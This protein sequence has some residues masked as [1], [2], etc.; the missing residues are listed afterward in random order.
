[1][2]DATGEPRIERLS[3]GIPGLDKILS[4]GFI[5][6]GI[7]IVQGNPGAGK[8]ILGNQIC[9]NHIGG[10]GKAAFITLLAESHA[11]MMLNLSELSFFNP[12]VIPKSLYYMSAYSALETEGLKG[13]LELVR[14]E[15]RGHHAS[16][17]VID[18]LVAAE[19]FAETD[20]DLKKFIHELQ[21]Q[22]GLYNCTTLLLTS[23]FGPRSMRPERTMVDGIIELSD[24][25]FSSRRERRLEVTKFRGSAHLRGQHQFEI[26]SDGIQVYPRVES[27]WA[28]PSALQPTTH[29]KISIGIRGLDDMLN[30]GLPQGTTSMILGPPGS[31]KTSVGLHFLSQC[32]EQERGLYF[33]SYTAL[34]RTVDQAERLGL[35]MQERIDRDIIEF[36]WNPLTE[37]LLDALGNQLIAAATQPNMRRVFIDGF[38]AFKLAAVEPDRIVPFFTAIV[39]EFRVRG[40]TTL[41]TGETRVTVGPE[42]ESPPLGISAVLEN[43]ISLRFAEIDSRLRRSISVFKARDTNFDASVREFAITDNGIEVGG[44]FK[45]VEAVLTGMPRRIP[46]VKKPTQKPT[47]TKAKSHRRKRR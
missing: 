13:L 9:F 32:T 27:G 31:G 22:S 4:G 30:G 23:G 33:S 26:T 5:K 1:M 42:I 43:W 39:N 8:T 41:Y 19:E 18:G 10:G 46:Q 14:R 44:P 28:R 3:T 24:H 12:E 16:I 40:I 37:N 34:D 47:R 6:G 29:S 45:G 17:L 35:R 25:L 38:D 7:Y 2:T 36:I 11:R 20:K 21:S 15:V